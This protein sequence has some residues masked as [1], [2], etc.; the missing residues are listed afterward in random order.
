[1]ESS[2]FIFISIFSIWRIIFERC[3]HSAAERY[4]LTQCAR[5]SEEAFSL[6][7]LKFKESYWKSVTN[8]V[9]MFYGFYALWVHAPQFSDPS[10]MFESWPQVMGTSE[11]IYYRLAIG[12]HGHR[13]IYGLFWEKKRSDYIAVRLRVNFNPI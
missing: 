5:T 10:S 9:L 6:N 8:S 3:I 7:M 13:A 11:L 1:M 2:A 4:A 12:Y